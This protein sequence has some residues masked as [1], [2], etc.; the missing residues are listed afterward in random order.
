LEGTGEASAPPSATPDS[1]PAAEA[2][3]LAGST[4]HW[5]GDSFSFTCSRPDCKKVHTINADESSAYLC[6]LLDFP[7]VDAL[8][9]SLHLDFDALPAVTQEDGDARCE[10]HAVTDE[11]AAVFLRRAH[12][13]LGH[14]SLRVLR[15]LHRS[16]ELLGPELTDD[17]FECVQ[18]HCPTCQLTR[19]TR[20]AF[21]R[22]RKD[23]SRSVRVLDKVI[24]DVVGPRVVPSVHFRGDRGNQTGGG[25]LFAVFYL[26]DK[27][28]CV[29]V[30]I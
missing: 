24:V 11:Q 12:Q 15:Q 29:F 10:A 27:T 21:L 26:D 6:E 25:N 8:A 5:S 28:S 20:K 19:Q 30:D 2:C 13:R 16:G 1:K 18:F 9:V 23:S 4:Q 7:D 22:R 14:A 3:P 17:Q